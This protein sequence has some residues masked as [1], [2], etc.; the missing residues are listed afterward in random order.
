MGPFIVLIAL[1]AGLMAA[2]VPLE[3]TN[4]S[5]A[6]PHL[7]VEGPESPGRRI[8]TRVTRRDPVPILM[9]HVIAPAP[10]GAP[11]PGLYVSPAR[12]AAHM[13]YL[14][15]HRYHVVTL[16]QV[17]SHWHG[18]TKLP[19]KPVVISFDDGF[20]NWYTHA[21]PVLRKHGW[22]GTM[23][24]AGNHLS[25]T[26]GRDGWVR[27]LVAAGWELDSHTLSHPDLTRLGARS[28]RREV[29]GSRSMLRKR[30]HVPVNFFCYPSGRYDARVIAA[31]RDAGYLG[32]TTTIEGAAVPSERF[33]LRR[34]RV[35][36][37]DGAASLGAKLASALG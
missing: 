9:Y 5:F 31:V 35:N 25:R 7:I 11:Y 12:F 15:R 24:L 32:A 19:S 26:G 3:R 17:W 2:G 28:L 8:T 30:F 23:N 36:G 20:R 33:T 4:E 34:V 21:Y 16:Q 18:G 1:V 14:D 6:V 22:V 37:G 27:K 13:A 29:A 10:S